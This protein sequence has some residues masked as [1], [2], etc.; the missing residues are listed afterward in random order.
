MRIAF[1]V[2]GG[3]ASFPGLRKPVT[4]DSAQLSPQRAQ[5][6]HALVERAQFFKAAPPQP[7]SGADQR[8]YTVEIDD[9]RQCRTMTLTE[10]IA[11]AGLREL[12]S[13]IRD[14]ARE[15]RRG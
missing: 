4:L 15:V 8:A 5:R 7:P 13:E 1:S 9:G 14:C 2:D 11:D 12:V 3:L 10:P 6:L